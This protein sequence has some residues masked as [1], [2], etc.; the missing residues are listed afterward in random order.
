MAAIAPPA[1][2]L[3]RITLM[4]TLSVMENASLIESL[5]ALM[6]CQDSCIDRRAQRRKREEQASEIVVDLCA[7]RVFYLASGRKVSA[8]STLLPPPRPS[9]LEG[10]T[11]DCHS[12]HC[13]KQTTAEAHRVTSCRDQMSETV[14]PVKENYQ[15]ES[16]KAW[17][18]N[19]VCFSSSLKNKAVET[20]KKKNRSKRDR[21]SVDKILSE[22]RFWVEACP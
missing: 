20:R 6:L 10:Y 15:C 14:C 18:Y 5:I 19:S 3:P 1:P 21:A 2:A 4:T 16:M 7:E 13:S 17:P 22:L 9:A 12:Q 8:I 11:N